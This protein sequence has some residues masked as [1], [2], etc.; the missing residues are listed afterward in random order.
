MNP[1]SPQEPS[2]PYSSASLSENNR[3]HTKQT[4]TLITLTNVE[5]K[6]RHL[7]PFHR[8]DSAITPTILLSDISLTINAYDIISV[9]GPNGA[10]KSTLIKLILGLIQPS[11]GQVWKKTNLIMGYVPQKF[12]IPSIMPL[13]VIDLLKQAQP[14]RLTEAQRQILYDT[15]NIHD[16]LYSQLLYLSGGETQR[17]LMARALLEKPDLLILDEPMQGLD[18]ETEAFLYQFID[19]LP[20]FLR[21]AILM[22][23]HDLHW[24][25]QG[26]RHVI[27]LNKHIC[28]EG[29]PSDLLLSDGFKQLFGHHYQLP[30]IHR[31][32]QCQHK[33]HLYNAS[34]SQDK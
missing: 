22:V 13:R 15:L 10:G 4:D 28:C 14:N 34:K 33:C 30:Y 29:L 19:K 25:M 5:Y 1:T 21:C 24:V 12:H 23:S 26:S 20:N 27:C 18:S 32:H 6:L 31:H 3:T 9:I 7:K 17:V 2:S 16:L 11:S 8:T